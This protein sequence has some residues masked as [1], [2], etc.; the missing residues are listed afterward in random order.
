MRLVLPETFFLS[1]DFHDLWH[2]VMSTCLIIEVK[3]QMSDVITWMGDHLS[4]RP[5]MGCI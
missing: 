3:Q 2:S 5:V 4:S 1:L